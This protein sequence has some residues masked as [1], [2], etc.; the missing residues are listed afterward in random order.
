[1]RE[2]P[3]AMN[4]S[5]KIRTRRRVTSRIALLLSL[6][7]VL[8]ACGEADDG[9]NASA[10]DDTDVGDDDTD[11]DDGEAFYE[12]ETIEI[13]VP[14][15]PGGG[16]DTTGR[17]AAELITEYV[18]G[19]PDVT[20][21][22]IDGAGGITGSN[23]YFQNRD[24]DGLSLVTGGVSPSISW[25]LD[26]PGVEYDY[27]EMTV[28]A[29]FPGSNVVLANTDVVPSMAAVA[30][31]DEP[32]FFG[33][34]DPGTRDLMILLAW[35][36]LGLRDNI[37]PVFGYEGAGPEYVALE[38]GE[39]DMMMPFSSSYAEEVETVEAMGAAPI[40]SL[41][42]P[43]GQGGFERDPQAPDTPTVQEVYEEMYGE[44][45]SGELWDAYATFA[46]LIVGGG[47]T[48]MMHDDAPDE[49]YEALVTGI[50]E[51]FENPDVAEQGE[52]ILT[53]PPLDRDQLQAYVGSLQNADEDALRT[54]REFLATE[55]DVE[56]G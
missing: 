23:E 4:H 37:E 11:S 31:A 29:A 9:T 10:G 3:K 17:F 56:T 47:I 18:D 33:G 35:E 14:F 15:S 36:V 24:A 53:G 21:S 52:D 43:D 27:A 48:V 32:I 16:A 40:M 55:Y 19:N 51:A 39:I 46:E 25:L 38:Q 41:G 12:G 6:M 45:P 20:V 13:V 26:V 7:L 5:L 28:V 30:D 44:E 49:A 2:L 1:M 54:A 42:I 34:R 22:N 50:Q 8:A